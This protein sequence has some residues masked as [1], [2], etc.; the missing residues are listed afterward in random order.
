MSISECYCIFLM[1]LEF[2]FKSGDVV[3]SVIDTYSTVIAAIVIVIIL[4][5]IFKIPILPKI[6][7]AARML[8]VIAIK[9]SFI[10]L[11]R[12]INIAKIASSTEV[13]VWI[14]DL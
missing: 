13:N 3:N 10:D 7:I 12:S 1:L 9:D 5:G 11:N 14:C 2:H 4:R 6:T 8:G